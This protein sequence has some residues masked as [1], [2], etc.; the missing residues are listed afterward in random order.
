M[1]AND[2]KPAFILNPRDPAARRL[3]GSTGR[4]AV[5]TLQ[6]L[7]PNRPNRGETYSPIQETYR[8]ETTTTYRKSRMIP[9]ENLIRPVEQTERMHKMYKD[10]PP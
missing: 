9:G 6:E 1:T 4:R 8:L 2:P 7:Q 5:A 3:D 10:Q